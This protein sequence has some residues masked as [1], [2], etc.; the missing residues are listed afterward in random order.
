MRKALKGMVCPAGLDPVTCGLQTRKFVD[1][2][3]HAGRVGGYSTGRPRSSG[4]C[5]LKCADSAWPGWLAITQPG[6]PGRFRHARNTE[7]D[8]DS[9]G[10]SHS[11][12]EGDVHDRQAQVG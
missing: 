12:M 1:P 10:G 7:P 5:T 4:P 3:E 2:G 6:Q 8:P 11:G 9:V